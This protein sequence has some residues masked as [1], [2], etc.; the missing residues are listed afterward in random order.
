MD[1]LLHDI[2]NRGAIT[3]HLTAVRLGDTALTYGELADRIED[4]DIVLAEQ[5]LSHTAA[6]YAALMHCMPSLAEIRPVEARM[7]VIGEIQ[8]WLGRE[9][10]EVAE[11]A[12]MRP[13]LR[14]VS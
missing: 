13:R 1:D 6:F 8:A 3:P 14:A 11:V 5:G 2:H 10:G 4:Y 9:R 7:Q 12:P